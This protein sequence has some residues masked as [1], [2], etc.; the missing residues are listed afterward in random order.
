MAIDDLDP[1]GGIPSEVLDK[2]PPLPPGAIEDDDLGEQGDL[3]DGGAEDLDLEDQPE[4]PSEPNA[5]GK[6]ERLNRRWAKLEQQAQL[7]QARAVA[8][9]RELAA[10]R[11]QQT[12]GLRQQQEEQA[13]RQEELEVASLPFEQQIE[14]RLRKS[15]QQHQTAMQRM[16]LQQHIMTDQ[17]TYLAKAAADADMRRMQAQVEATF[18]ERLNSGQ[19]LPREAIFTYLFG[20]EQ[21][22]KRQGKTRT[23]SPGVQ[24]QRVAA[25]SGGRNDVAPARSRGGGRAETLEQREERLSRV[26]F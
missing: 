9:E 13:R 4:A 17:N 21:L 20:Q 2:D 10:L 1:L 18:Y 3:T 8:L 23:A 12:M 15:E 22:Q 14:Y 5:R 26:R 25:P 11:E 24:R 7:E 19:F 16:Q 6:S